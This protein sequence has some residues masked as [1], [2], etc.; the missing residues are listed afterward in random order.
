MIRKWPKNFFVRKPIIHGQKET[1]YEPSFPVHISQGVVFGGYGPNDND[2][3]VYIPRGAGVEEATITSYYQVNSV[4]CEPYGPTLENFYKV[5][6]N[7][8]SITGVQ[9]S[10]YPTPIF[11]TW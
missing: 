11:F 10:S 1:T 4:D 6:P 3:T 5:F 8:P 2:S 9:N 7:D